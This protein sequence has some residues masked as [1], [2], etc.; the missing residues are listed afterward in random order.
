MNGT[1]MNQLVAPTS[2]ITSISRRRANIAIRMVLRMSRPAANSRKPATTKMPTV[3]VL[4]RSWMSRIVFEARMTS[5]TPARSRKVLASDSTL[6][7]SLF[8][9]STRYDGRQ[10]LGPHAVDHLG[11]VGEEPLE[12]LVGRLLVEVLDAGDLGALLEVTADR[13]DLLG[14]GRRC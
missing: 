4:E 2:F 8:T 5:F 6:S 3:N 1:R 7:A 12:L 9:G 14:G 10:V 13:V 11:R